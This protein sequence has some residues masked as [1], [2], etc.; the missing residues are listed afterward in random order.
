MTI[1]D[2]P[3]IREAERDGMPIADT[4]HCPCCGAECER[5]YFLNGGIDVLGCENCVTWEDSFEWS[6]EHGGQTWDE[7]L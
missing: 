2:A 4:V 7:K 3:W 1:A 5:F 6:E